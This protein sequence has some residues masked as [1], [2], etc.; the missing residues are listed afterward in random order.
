M[1]APC[2]TLD[3]SKLFLSPSTLHAKKYV[4]NRIQK[5]RPLR[6]AAYTHDL[7]RTVSLY[8]RCA[9]G[10]LLRQQSL[11]ARKADAK[12]CNGCSGNILTGCM[13][14]LRGL[15]NGTE[16]RLVAAEGKRKPPFAARAD[17]ESWTSPAHRVLF[18]N[19]RVSSDIQRLSS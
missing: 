5:S 11:A 3:V 18:H 7:S 4:K 15:K 1:C 17:K 16:Q 14:P 6:K 19:F 10:H 2:R 13:R 12:A 9:S 8:R